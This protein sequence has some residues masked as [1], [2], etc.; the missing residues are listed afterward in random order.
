MNRDNSSKEHAKRTCQYEMPE[1]STKTQ[2]SKKASPFRGLPSSPWAGSCRVGFFFRLE[3]NP[4]TQY[5]FRLL[6]LAPDWTESNV[7]TLVK[8]FRAGGPEE[9]AMYRR[10]WAGILTK[11]VTAT[12]LANIVLGLGDDDD[13]VERFK[14]AWE[15]GNFKWLGVDITP[16]Y[17]ALGGKTEARKY[18]SLF[19]HFQDPMKFIFHPVRSAHHSVTVKASMSFIEVYQLDKLIAKHRRCW[20]RERQIFEPRHYLELLERK[21]GAL[22]HARPLEDWSLPECFNS[23]RRCLEA[24]RENGTKE[25]IQ[26]LLLLNKYSVGQLAKAI[27]KALN[28]RIYCYDAI[29]QFLL[30]REDYA[31]TTFSLAGRDHLRQVLV[32]TTSV[33]AYSSL[34]SGGNRA[35]IA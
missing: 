23:Y 9:T 33:S 21:P 6:A 17:R 29:L 25:Y 8:A 22:D 16:I 1:N 32:N 30:T 20:D 26:I 31:F 7:R 11:G 10:F 19:G 12:I 2:K 27:A 14:K 35:K 13:T 5:I 24:H 28:Y 4:T 18:F 15:A 3:R 34:V